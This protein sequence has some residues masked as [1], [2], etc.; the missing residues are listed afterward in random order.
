MKSFPRETATMNKIKVSAVICA[1][2]KGE[3]AGFGKNKLLTPLFGAPALYHTLKKF[4]SPL[5]DEVIVTASPEDLKEISA[6][7]AP[8]GYVA[9][10]GGAS[11]TESVK[12]ALKK[13]N[14]DIVLI[15]DG[16]RPF[17]STALIEKCIAETEK[18]GS[19]ICAVKFTDTAVFCDY[20]LITERLDR[21]RLYCVQTPQGFLTED[22]KKAYELADR[23]LY[24]DDSAVYGKFIAQPHIIDGEPTNTKLTYREDFMRETAPKN[25]SEKNRTGF[26]VDVH[27]FGKGNSVI[28]AG[29]KIP[30]TMGLIA[31][32]DGDVVLHAVCDALLSAAGLKDIGTYFP[33]SNPALKGA[34]SGEM[35]EKVVKMLEN[36]AYVP[37]NI[38]VSVQAESPRL[39]PYIDDMKANIARR[40]GLKLTDIAVA[41]GTCEG[42]GFVGE[43]L[44]I[45]AYCTV[46][47][48][49]I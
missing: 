11:R 21:D 37:L 32:S 49:E 48:K 30:H 29:V 15:H 42:L 5:I 35:L 43:R 23:R 24:T 38:S 47:L 9:V 41:A 39:A 7:C 26:G 44:G 31:H 6:L 19:A 4:Q 27:A 25:S 10:L 2:G 20:G 22:I 45:A 33:D 28:L 16:A 13:V 17:L 3:R 36:E 1:A 18:F 34:D 14:G 40:T 46:L 12:N 8:F